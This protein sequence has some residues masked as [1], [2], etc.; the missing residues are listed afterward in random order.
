MAAVCRSNPTLTTFENA[1]DLFLTLPPPSRAL[2]STRGKLRSG[3]LH[4]FLVRSRRILATG[5]KNKFV[6]W[7]QRGAKFVDKMPEGFSFPAPLESADVGL[8]KDIMH[9]ALNCLITR[10][11]ATDDLF[12]FLRENV[13][14]KSPEHDL[15]QLPVTRRVPSRRQN[16][17]TLTLILFL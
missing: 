12:S 15:E 4:L 14:R 11:R 3:L 10:S 5:D 16:T 1:S 7:Q 13:P 2:K 8:L 6:S 9:H 17:H